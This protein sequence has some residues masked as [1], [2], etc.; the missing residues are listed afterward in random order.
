MS[1]QFAIMLICVRVETW[2]EMKEFIS[3]DSDHGATIIKTASS[4]DPYVGSE[5]RYR[6]PPPRYGSAKARV[7]PAPE[8]FLETKKALK[9]L[10]EC[11]C[12]MVRPTYV[13]ADNV[14][15]VKYM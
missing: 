11:W 6:T 3:Q 4:P 13:H 2:N 5:P 15:H 7:A 9:R 14:I 8:G 10:S 12:T 1:I